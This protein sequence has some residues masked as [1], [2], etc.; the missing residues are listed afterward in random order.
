M[1]TIRQG[2]NGIVYK[3]EGK[4]ELFVDTMELTCRIND[5]LDEENMDRTVMRRL[6]GNIMKPFN[7]TRK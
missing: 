3:E 4:A 2:P 5:N 7:P 6:E 1:E